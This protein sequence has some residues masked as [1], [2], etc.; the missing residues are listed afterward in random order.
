MSTIII[1][2]LD[3][4]FLLQ[5]ATSANAL[6]RIYDVV[7]NKNVGDGKGNML[8]G[9][10]EEMAAIQQ[11]MTAR[12]ALLKCDDKTRQAAFGESSLREKLV[13]SEDGPVLNPPRIAF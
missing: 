10:R 7:N 6:F 11:E 5:R 2:G 4:R 12:V 8:L 3:K 1:I 9:T 13:A